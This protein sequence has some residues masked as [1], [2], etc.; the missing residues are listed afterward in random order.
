MPAPGSRSA[1]TSSRQFGGHND[2]T[3]PAGIDSTYP[4]LQTIPDGI[5]DGVD[6][7]RHKVREMVRAGADW[8]KI[9]T[10]GGVGTPTGGPLLRQF[11]LEE[12]RAIVDT[13]HAAGKPVMSHADGGEGVKICLDAGVDSIE[14]GAALDDAL[15]EQ[16]VRQKTWLVPTFTVLH[17]IVALGDLDPCPVPDYM[18]AQGP[19]PHGSPARELPKALAAGVRMA[20]GTDLGSFGRG[21][22]AGELAYMTAAGM[23]PMQAIVAATRMGAACMGLGGE[24][25]E[26]RPGLY[27]DLLVIDGDPLEDV[28]M[29]QDAARIQLVMQGGVIHKNRWRWELRRPMSLSNLIKTLTELPGPGGDE[30]HVQKW[31]IERWA[32]VSGR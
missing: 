15:I 19:N 21:E 8:I 22:N 27:A 25:G 23:T 4:K 10:T 17:K 13:A 32:I 3:E 30:W 16:M 29:L 14:H 2:H 31:L 11:S 1:S 6:A 18:P 12:V 28:A 20:M 24:V 7:C 9:A 5:C 26:I